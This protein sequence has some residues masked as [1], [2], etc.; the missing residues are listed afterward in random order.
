MTKVKISENKI[1]FHKKV[2]ALSLVLRVTVGFAEGRD[3]VSIPGKASIFSDF[4]YAIAEVASVTA[5]IL[6]AFTPSTHPL[7]RRKT[8]PEGGIL[9]RVQVYDRVGVSVV[10]VHG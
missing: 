6:F 9:C 1:Y 10:E 5:M 2:L 8:P 3:G 7:P 4:L